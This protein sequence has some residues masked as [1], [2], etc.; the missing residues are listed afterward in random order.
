MVHWLPFDKNLSVNTYSVGYTKNLGNIWSDVYTYVVFRLKASAI[1]ARLFYLRNP[2]SPLYWI[3]KKSA[4]QVGFCVIFWGE[5]CSTIEWP[6][7]HEFKT[8][9]LIAWNFSCKF[10]NKHKFSTS[11]IQSTKIWHSTFCQFLNIMKRLYL[12]SQ[13]KSL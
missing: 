1:L 10:C 5:I 7:F 11:D 12:L 2:S 8:Q 13:P 4:C 3:R 9:F 6:V